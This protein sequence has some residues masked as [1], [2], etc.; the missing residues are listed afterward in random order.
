[1]AA[2]DETKTT[3]TVEVELAF[4][5]ATKNTYRFKGDGKSRLDQVYLSQVGGAPGKTPS[6]LK[7][8]AEVIF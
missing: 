2:K 8:R 7:I 3:E 5:K 4:D 6:A 1:M